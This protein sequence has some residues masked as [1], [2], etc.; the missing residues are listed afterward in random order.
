MRVAVRRRS[1][2]LPLLLTS[3]KTG[4][5]L[6]EEPLVI[7]GPT[8]VHVDEATCTLKL[9]HT[10][11]LPTRLQIEA[12]GCAAPATLE[13]TPTTDASL[14]LELSALPAD[15]DPEE[16][17]LQS[18]GVRVWTGA[19]EHLA[20][21]TGHRTDLRGWVSLEVLSGD[22]VYHD[23]PFRWVGNRPVE[24]TLDALPA[25]GKPDAT[26][27]EVVFLW[28]AKRDER[29]GELRLSTGDV[30]LPEHGGHDGYR[31][32]RLRL[33]DRF[34]RVPR[35]GLRLAPREGYPAPFV[36]AVGLRRLP[37]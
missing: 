6:A 34:G 29:S 4:T 7:E 37:R 1:W 18:F 12:T 11:E 19:D 15:R 26:Q 23:R 21:H 25:D 31:W 20:D 8:F 35:L 24:V 36:A 27:I 16:P 14:V 30:I 33:P 2:L 9:R 3:C 22:G 17:V 32:T 10:F 5:A 28:G 13:L